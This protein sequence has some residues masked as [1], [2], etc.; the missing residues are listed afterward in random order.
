MYSNRKNKPNS[1][2][3]NKFKSPR[4]IHMSTAVACFKWLKQQSKNSYELLACER[5]LSLSEFS[6]ERNEMY[7]KDRQEY[8]LTNSA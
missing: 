6:E 2:S 1:G 5:K 4:A 8:H 7:E 3:S